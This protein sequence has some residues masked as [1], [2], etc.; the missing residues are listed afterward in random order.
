[1][2]A[3]YLFINRAFYYKVPFFA[4]C[5]VLCCCALDMEGQL[6]HPSACNDIQNYSQPNGQFFTLGILK[7]K[8]HLYLFLSTETRFKGTD[9]IWQYA[10]LYLDLV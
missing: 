3:F 2:R 7:N 8:H 1:M 6:T 9:S 10:G 4:V 5:R